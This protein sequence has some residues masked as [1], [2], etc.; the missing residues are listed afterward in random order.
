MI[1]VYQFFIFFGSFK[2][3]WT[4]EVGPLMFNDNDEIDIL[5]FEK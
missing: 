5:S 2:V 3:L 4:N 1:L